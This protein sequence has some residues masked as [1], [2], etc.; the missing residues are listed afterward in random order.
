LIATI[1]DDKYFCS[2]S[3]LRA[4]RISER[5]GRKADALKMYSASKGC[6]H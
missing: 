5:L 6:Q 1:Y 3:L 4:A 2:E